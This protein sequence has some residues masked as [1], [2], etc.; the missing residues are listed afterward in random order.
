MARALLTEVVFRAIFVGNQRGE[1]CTFI[2]GFYIHRLW[3]QRN[4]SMLQSTPSSSNIGDIQQRRSYL[5]AVMPK[6][7]QVLLTPKIS[8]DQIW[9]A[10]YFGQPLIYPY[11]TIFSSKF[12][13]N[14]LKS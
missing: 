14:S 7:V 5:R 4:E 6:K 9:V 12:L 3:L 2:S 8:S 1:E 10:G 11:F 13:C